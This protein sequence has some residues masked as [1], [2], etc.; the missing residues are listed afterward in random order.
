LGLILD[1]SVLIAAERRMQP[2]S[3][4]LAA[5]CATTGFDNIMISAISVTELEH[6]TGRITA[7]AAVC[8]STKSGFLIGRQWDLDRL[9]NATD[10]LR[11]LTVEHSLRGE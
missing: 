8:E 10:N 4:M 9:D 5:V 6:G 11:S 3:E 1:S 7:D 2:V